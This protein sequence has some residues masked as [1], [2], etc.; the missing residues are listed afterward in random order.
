MFRGGEPMAAFR[1]LPGVTRVD[2]HAL[3]H[4]GITIAVNHATRAAVADQFRLVELVEI[5]HGR[6]Q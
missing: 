1:G 6:S 3:E 2:G 4:A 5:A